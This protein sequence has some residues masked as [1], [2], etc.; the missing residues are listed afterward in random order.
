MIL[1]GGDG[2]DSA[3]LDGS[4]RHAASQRQDD[5]PID[6]QDAR[7][8]PREG[9]SDRVQHRARRD[10]LHF[11]DRTGKAG[12][13]HL[14]RR[15]D[16]Y[17]QRRA[18]GRAGVHTGADAPGDRPRTERK[19]SDHRRY[20]RRLLLQRPGL[21][22]ALSRRLE[23]RDLFGFFRLSRTGTEDLHGIAQSGD[24]RADCRRSRLRLAGFCRRKLV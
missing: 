9:R 8:L 6:A 2:H 20:R 13:R 22:P 14:Q 4:G 16:D 11:F 10:P 12:F 7:P 23:P 21:R 17:A 24:R 19:L 3:A 1:A 5:L 15:C 18:G